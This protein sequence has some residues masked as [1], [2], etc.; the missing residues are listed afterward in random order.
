[1]RPWELL[2][3]EHI[4]SAIKA[5]YQNNF[6]AGDKRP[7]CLQRLYVYDDEPG[8]LLCT[9]PMGGKPRFPFVYSDEVWTG[10][11]YQVAT[12]LIYEGFVKEGLEI[13]SAVRKRYDG[14]RRNPFSEIE[15]GYHYARSLSSYG[16][17]VALSGLTVSP[18]GEVTFDPHIG[19][20]DFHCFYCDGR[21]FGLLHQ[22]VGKME[23]S[24]NPLKYC[25][26]RLLR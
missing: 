7:S 18:G 19:E 5:V 9:W 15:C 21:H 1:M 12:L 17:L 10:I 25:N 20:E 14:I 8:L 13:V 11:E 4:Q 23:R 24:I 26:R 2:P 3:K 16:V 6:L 22:T